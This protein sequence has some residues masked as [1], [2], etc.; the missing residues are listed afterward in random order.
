M[1]AAAH[2]YNEWFTARAWKS[3]PRPD[4]YLPWDGLPLSSVT[5]PTVAACLYLTALVLVPWLRRSSAPFEMPRVVRDCGVGARGTPLHCICALCMLSHVLG[6]LLGLGAPRVAFCWCLVQPCCDPVALCCVSVLGQLLYHNIFL[7]SA[8]V[9]MFVGT[10]TAVIS[11]FVC[12]CT[13]VPCD[14]APLPPHP[15]ARQPPRHAHHPACAPRP[16]P[17]IGMFQ[18]LCGNMTCGPFGVTTT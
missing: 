17:P 14:A 10:L 8:S 3:Q 5:A 13:S 7:A 2:W 6:G 11:E 16:P 1:D 9:I 18:V 15:S 4:E 12:G